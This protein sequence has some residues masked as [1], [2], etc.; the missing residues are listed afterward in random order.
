M[1]NKRGASVRANK[2][3][4]VGIPRLK[5]AISPGT[6]GI[7]PPIVEEGFLKQWRSALNEDKNL[8][9]TMREFDAHWE[10]ESAV[11]DLNRNHSQSCQHHDAVLD[12]HIFFQWFLWRELRAY[13]TYLNRVVK[14]NRS[15][16]GCSETLATAHSDV[17]RFAAGARL[18]PDLSPLLK[19]LSEVHSAAEEFEKNYW[20]RVF[21]VGSFLIKQV[22]DWALDRSNFPKMRP[23]AES[24]WFPLLEQE[25]NLD[26]TFQIRV[27]DLLRKY[28]PNPY[29]RRLSLLT[30]SRLVLLVYI[31]AN[32]ATDVDGLLTIWGSD[33]HRKLTVDQT[34][35]TLRNAGLR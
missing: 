12:P 25:R 13:G 10:Y 2:S 19:Q 7:V 27:G 9:K 21:C 11:A 6:E 1:V 31:C 3:I 32:L 24:I 34:Y 4:G 35:E 16:R 18:I 26:T 22:E 30:I 17:E 15:L 14:I 23:I 8:H 28:I 29:G 5:G 33:P 20:D